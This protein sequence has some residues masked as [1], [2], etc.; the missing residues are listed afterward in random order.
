ML[1][2]A[3][4]ALQSALIPFL[5]TAAVVVLAVVAAFYWMGPRGRGRP[6]RDA[7]DAA[8]PVDDSNFAPDADPPGHAGRA[9]TARPA[10]AL[11]PLAADLLVV[12]DSA[13]ARAKL[14]RLFATAGHEVHLARDGVEALAL[15][16]KGRYRLMITDLEM[17][18]LDGVALIGTCQSQPHTAGM[19]ILAI[20]GHDDLQ[21][22][23]N[24]CQEVCGIYRK[25]W[26]DGDLASHVALLLG[27]SEAPCAEEAVEP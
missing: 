6:P 13:V 25:P 22:R 17:P 5:I 24:E 26:I 20:T 27:M 2:P 7:P 10:A 15:L 11:L 18:N 16:Q 23:L 1:S 19:P 4:A 3:L 12:D 9:A 21:A 14:R 8:A